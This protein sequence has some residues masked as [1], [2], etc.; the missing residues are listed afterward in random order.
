M[1]VL[2]GILLNCKGGGNLKQY[3]DFDLEE[4]NNINID[5]VSKF[6]NYSKTVKK[7]FNVES[8]FDIETSSVMLENEQKF[9]FMYEWTFGIK[10]KNF[11]C[12]GR[13]WEEFKDLC[14]QLQEYF[15][16][17]SEHIL[18][19]Y[20]HNLS[21]EFQFMRKYFNWLDVFAVDE[22]KPVKALCSYGIEFRDS[23]IL[24]GYSLEKLAENLVSHNI[25][26][27]VGDLDYN[28]TRTYIT[29]L[30]ENE[31]A[32]CNN[33]V[34]IVLAYINEQIE[35][36]GSIT[37]IPMTNTGRVRN[38]V[39]D[40][41]YF[42]GKNHRKSSKGKYQRY[43]ELMNE[44]TLTTGEYTMLKRCFMGG[45]THASMLYSGKLLHDVASI[46]FTSSYPY[47]ML[48]EKFPMS[49]P[50]KVKPTKEQFLKWV[51]DDNVGLMFVVRFKGLQSKLSFETYLSESK[52]DVLENP[53]INNG[54][55]FKA[56]TVQTTITDIDFKILYKCYTWDSIE[57]AN[58]HKFY[59]QYLPK[60]ILL[61]I[62]ELY[63]KKTTLKDVSGKEVEYLV[64]KGMLN[65][66]YGMCVTDIV[67]DNISYKDDWQLEKYTIE[68]MNEQ[69]EKYNSS[70]NRFLYYPWGVWVTA[71]ARKNLWNGI[72][73]IGID[74]VY[75][76]TDSVKFLNYEKHKEYINRY[77]LD[78]ERKLKKMCKFRQ[79]EFER[80]K[81]KTIKGVEKMIG[82]WD[83]EGVYTHFKTLGA[84]RYLVRSKK[85]EKLHLTVAGLSKQNGVE[86]MLRICNND[87]EKVF[88]NFN[89]DLYIPEN[90]TG[91][92][93]HTYIDSPI[94]SMITDYQNNV[95]EVTALSGVH[96]S[97]CEFTLSI[98][99]QYSKFLHD[100]RNGYLFTG[101][102][103]I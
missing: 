64:N 95:V 22:R 44:L 24:S 36:Y 23:Y 20:V 93:T 39:K 15:L 69:I 99:Q 100:L 5:I 87:Y 58:V 76:D 17:D 97:P 35:Q 18:V 70:S 68:M 81:P 89:D 4:L 7:Y 50:E 6:D 42:T 90:E 12:Y 71:Y 3:Q 43:K 9:A 66:V 80:L 83:F 85:D 82:V 25:K 60:P 53:I 103:A 86:Y 56:D 2:N 47:V 63:E 62:V 67:R 45:F 79:I 59:M 48:S 13:T 41:C 16:L 37:K 11:I 94:T 57:I 21:Y 49:K 91:K 55:V 101:T 73:E 61:A 52:C 84:K 29:E 14:R 32:Y 31:L 78:V 74:Y 26:K 72:L 19:V 88:A 30:T 40:K 51:N 33:D 34:E 27:L 28:L 92:H 46:D 38:F 98:S 96:L 75:S 10:D 65:S 54:R 1:V 77:N 8:A 102:R